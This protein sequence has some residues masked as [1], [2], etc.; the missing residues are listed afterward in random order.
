MKPF[1]RMSIVNNNYPSAH[2]HSDEKIHIEKTTH[3]ISSLS[4]LGET[5]EN[6]SNE[7]IDIEF[8]INTQKSQV[9]VEK[10]YIF[11]TG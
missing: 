4:R 6:P 1:R 3:F 9:N 10:C 5:F 7:K 8:L 11:K 2:K